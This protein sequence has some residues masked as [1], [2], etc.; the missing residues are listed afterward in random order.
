MKP[1]I[2]ISNGYLDFTI[3][4]PS[5]KSLRNFFLKKNLI[6]EKISA[7]KNI[8]LEIFDGERVGLV[9][10]NGAG[11]STLL[12]VI[13][14]IYQLTNGIINV[15]GDMEVLLENEIGLEMDANGLENI[16]LILLLS[17][18]EKREIDKRIDWIINFSGLGDDIYRP[19]RT[20][21]SGMITRLT[22]ASKLS[23]SPDILVLD[24]FF[25]TADAEFS[26]K[27]NNR[28]N[29]VIQKS[30]VFICAS[31]NVE[32]INKLCTRVINLKK[33]EIISDKKNI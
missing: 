28:F 23:S 15:T 16:Y 25:G 20:Y 6:T 11:K 33:G 22:T 19:I 30:G 31:H 5:N 9:G 24:E 14:G 7:L 2:K 4:G 13:S 32:L 3:Y 17:G 27:V 18:V 29:E 8:N 1:R 21:S 12:R 26:E 10:S